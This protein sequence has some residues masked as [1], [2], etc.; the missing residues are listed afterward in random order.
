MTPRLLINDKDISLHVG[1]TI[2]YGNSRISVLRSAYTT[3]RAELPPLLSH[4]QTSDLGN[5]IEEHYNDLLQV[6]LAAKGPKRQRRH[7]HH[8]LQLLE[9]PLQSTTTTTSHPHFNNNIT[10]R[11]SRHGSTS[12]SWW[13]N[14]RRQDCHWRPRRTRHRWERTRQQP[15]W[16][17]QNRRR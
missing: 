6:G 2:K 17:R 4:Y 14:S 11:A 16:Y 13:Q 8:H 10:Y 15:L 9:S 3:C 5:E 12:P 1:Y 7:H